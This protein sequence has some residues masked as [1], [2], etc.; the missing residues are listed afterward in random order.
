MP[1][2]R[3]SG[4]NLHWK[5][6]GT[7]CSFQ[8][9]EERRYRVRI[10]PKN[11][12]ELSI[13]NR[14]SPIESHSA[15]FLKA[16]ELIMARLLF[17][18]VGTPQRR[19]SNTKFHNPS[20]DLFQWEELSSSWSIRIYFMSLSRLYEAIFKI[21]IPYLYPFQ[22]LSSLVLDGQSSRWSCQFFQYCQK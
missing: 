20:Y 10:T 7:L 2:L 21:Y 1:K 18:R 11:E 3:K 6:R 4:G 19:A 9:K 14:R 15:L 13:M 16:L 22:T 8:R 17:E 5:E 12:D